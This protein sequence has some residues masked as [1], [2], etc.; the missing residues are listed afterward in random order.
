M[1]ATNGF[2]GGEQWLTRER[3]IADG[4]EHLM[5]HEFVGEAQSL[6]VEH[7]ILAH[8]QSIFERSAECVTRTPQFGNVAHETESTGARNL[9]AERVG[10]DVE[11]KR[12]LA[13]KRMIEIDLGFDTET[14]LVRPQLAICTIFGNRDGLDHLDIAAWQSPRGEAGLVDCIHKRSGAAIHDWHFG[15]VDFDDHVIDVEATHSCE[16]V[17]GGRAK[18][19][20]GIAKD[21]REFSCGNCA[22]VGANFA[23]D[24]A[25]SR[26]ALENNSA[27]IVSGMKCECNGES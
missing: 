3:Q 23:L 6:R 24:R 13:D 16:K 22:H 18:R 15:P 19:A 7:T 26:D 8:H 27:V 1:A 2:V 20:F 4:I 17:L 21:S 12:L 10:L 5:A 11:R 9:T 25:V 14:M